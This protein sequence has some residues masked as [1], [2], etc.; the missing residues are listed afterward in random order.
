MNLSVKNFKTD[1]NK[2]KWVRT[3]YA[4]PLMCE[5]EKTIESLEADK[6]LLKTAGEDLLEAVKDSNSQLSKSTEV[7]SLLKDKVKELEEI[8]AT[9]RYRCVT[10][11][12][13]VEPDECYSLVGTDVMACSD[14][15]LDAYE[16]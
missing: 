1:I 9:H 11:K 8:L 2:V 16:D 5:A 10:C 4:Y 3:D 6:A 7:V 12:R 15:C 13:S 14:K